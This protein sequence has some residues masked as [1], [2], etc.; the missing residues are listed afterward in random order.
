MNSRLDADPR[1]MAG[2]T[3]GEPGPTPAPTASD[4]NAALSARRLMIA[5][6]Q[7]DAEEYGRPELARALHRLGLMTEF[8][9]CLSDESP[10]AAA[11]VAEYCAEALERLT[12]IDAFNEAEVTSLV[13]HETAERW[14]DYLNLIEP[15]GGDDPT[16]EAPAP[17]PETTPVDETGPSIDPEMLLRLLAGTSSPAPKPQATADRPA[18]GARRPPAPPKPPAFAAQSAGDWDLL[19]LGPSFLDEPTPPANQTKPRLVLDVP[20]PPSSVDIDPELRDTFLAEATDLFDRIET[21]VLSL[22]GGPSQDQ[23]LHELGRCLHTLKGAAGSVDLTQL[24]ALIHGVEEVLEEAQGVVDDDLVDVLHKLLHYLEGVFQALQGGSTT[25]GYSAP[26]APAPPPRAAPA[27][28][29]PAANKPA[30]TPGGDRPNVAPA[31][32][33][34]PKPQA[35]PQAQAPSQPAT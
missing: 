3:P 31:T 27:A 16:V 12:S 24:A 23:A 33:P 6:L 35:R 29:A 32:A 14:G 21:L 15:G 8:C 9:E 18:P 13:L 2:R 26:P 28:P 34:H 20:A 7:A 22:V 10:D 19:G 5:S 17:A 30:P 25:S 4:S 11:E 1:P